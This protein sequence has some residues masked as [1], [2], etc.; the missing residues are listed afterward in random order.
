MK[1]LCKIIGHKTVKIRDI[2]KFDWETKCLRC[3]EIELWGKRMPIYNKRLENEDEEYW[4]KPL[5][6]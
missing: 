6:N 1:L 4:V 5:N 3:G 2:N